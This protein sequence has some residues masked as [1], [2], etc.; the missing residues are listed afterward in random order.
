MV[1]DGNKSRLNFLEYPYLSSK[2]LIRRN[3]L[4]THLEIQNFALIE[5]L[6]VSFLEGMTCITGE[7]G[8]GKSILLGGL[9]LVLGKR[10]EM[11]SLLDPSKKCVI[12]ATFDLKGYDLEPLFSS[13]DLEYDNQ[14][15]LRREILPQGKSRAFINDTPANLTQLKDLGILL[16]DLHS[17][18]ANNELSN[19][20]FL[21]NALDSFGGFAEYSGHYQ[22]KFNQYTILSNEISRLEE[23]SRQA[24]LEFDYHQFILNEIRE[25]DLHPN[26]MED[27][28]AEL[29]V[30]SH[31]EEIQVGLR[32]IENVFNS[33]ASNAVSILKQIE[34]QGE[35]LSKYSNELGELYSRVKSVRIELED[36]EQEYYL[37]QN[38]I[39][40]DEEKLFQ[41]RERINAIN[42][43][44]HKHQ[45][46]STEELLQKST[47]LEAK[48]SGVEKGNEEL[49]C[50]KKQKAESENALK[51]L[52]IELSHKRKKSAPLFSKEI[53]QILRELGMPKAQVN[54]EL[55]VKDTLDKYGQNNIKYLFSANQGLNA[56]EVN[57]IASGGENS[58]F[59]LAV[60]RILSISTEL[61]SIIFD[62]I[63][64]GISGEIAHKMGDIMKSISNSI[65]VIAI[66]HLPQVAAKGQNHL[67]V[68]KTEEDGKVKTA[69]KK[70]NNENRIIEL[71]KML[72]G[73]Q[74]SQAARENAKE[75]LES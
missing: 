16:V 36:I 59:M 55:G 14:T 35:A 28:E 47:D 25:L 70:L 5:H 31:S 58:R 10:A 71:A 45:L 2:F 18:F 66:T 57:R 27:K 73:E 68:Y 29:N 56:Q 15:L 46:K 39:E 65:Q 20:Q 17:Q 42:L 49:D 9:S 74:I 34:S 8:A 75:L 41:I 44:L 67:T 43:L 53:E 13:L 50:M 7:T 60:K 11:S 69:V 12:E 38:S 51:D 64:A 54:V 52:A 30:L 61:P 33:V 40:V 37:A 63:D 32:N 22:K 72:S 21:F 1:Q 3:A 48:V 26:E 24:Q 62:E 19:R 4:L 23:E 6:E